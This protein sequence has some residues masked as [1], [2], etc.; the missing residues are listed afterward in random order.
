MHLAVSLLC[1]AP[2]PQRFA[3]CLRRE[4]PDGFDLLLILF[5]GLHTPDRFCFS[6][7]YASS[8]AASIST[9][10][11][12]RRRRPPVHAAPAGSTAATDPARDGATPYPTATTE[13]TEG[14]AATRGDAEAERAAPCG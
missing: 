1:S 12:S 3:T 14:T 4:S 9:A 8:A 11:A 2:L 7:L 6:S 5:L 10:T 13:V